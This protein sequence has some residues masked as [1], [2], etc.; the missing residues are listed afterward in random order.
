M[1][2]LDE[3]FYPDGWVYWN[4]KDTEP[5][6]PLCLKEKNIATPLEELNTSD[7]ESNWFCKLH[8]KDFKTM[9]NHNPFL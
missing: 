1:S 3:R 9:N 6:C 4:R 7:N 8:N 5:F 2:K